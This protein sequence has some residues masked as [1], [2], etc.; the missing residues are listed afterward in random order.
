MVFVVLLVH[1]SKFFSEYLRL[2]NWNVTQILKYST[3]MTQVKPQG[4][5]QFGKWPNEYENLNSQWPRLFPARW[6]GNREINVIDGRHRRIKR[7]HSAAGKTRM[8]PLI[9]KRLNRSCSPDAPHWTF[10][11]ARRWH[12]VWTPWRRH[13][14][15]KVPLRHKPHYMALYEPLLQWLVSVNRALCSLAH[16]DGTSHKTLIGFPQSSSR[17]T[18]VSKTSFTA[19]NPDSE[20][21]ATSKCQNCRLIDYSNND[22]ALR[23]CDEGFPLENVT[24][25]WDN[26]LYEG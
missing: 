8:P 3:G 25:I 12:S 9:H 22:D 21:A 18:T 1:F 24:E 4:H 13:N 6:P 19:A 7:S 23:R 11:H 5:V 15:S 17:P 26:L 14:K 2:L 20:E 10:K 16:N